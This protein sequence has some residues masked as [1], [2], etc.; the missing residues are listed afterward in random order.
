MLDR[1]PIN[2]K[3]VSSDRSTGSTEAFHQDT[4]QI[5]DVALIVHVW[6]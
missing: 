4:S 5:I 1:Q 2:E 6:H 3:T